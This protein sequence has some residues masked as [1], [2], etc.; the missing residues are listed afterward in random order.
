MTG[1][2]EEGLKA[3]GQVVWKIRGNV[4]YSIIKLCWFQQ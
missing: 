1:L 2:F 4:H 3:K